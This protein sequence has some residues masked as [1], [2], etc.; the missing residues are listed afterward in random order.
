MQKPKDDKHSPAPPPPMTAIAWH[1]DKYY[2]TPLK[3]SDE[4]LGKLADWVT[5]HNITVVK[6]STNS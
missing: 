5:M 2:G 4:R 1:S 6:V 3:L